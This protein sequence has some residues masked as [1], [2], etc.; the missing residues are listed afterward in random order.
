MAKKGDPIIALDAAAAR[1]FFL[2]ERQYNTL[3]LPHYFSFQPVLDAVSKR[4]LSVPLK[5]QRATNPREMEGVNYRILTNKNGLY[6]WRPFELIHPALYVSLVHT[7][8]E[9]THWAEIKKRFAEFQTNRSIKCHSIPVVPN[10]GYSHQKAQIYNWWEEIEQRSIELAL[11]Y[12][13]IIH[14]DVTDCYGSIYTHSIHWALSTKPVAKV[15]KKSKGQ[16]RVGALIDDHLQDMNYGQT[17][18]IPQGSVLMDF[19]A[20]IVLGHVD[21]LLTDRLKKVKKGDY[22]IL[23]YRDDYRIFTKGSSLGE[24]ILKELSEVLT[25]MGLKLNASKT[26]ASQNII[27]SSVKADKLYWI[28]HGKRA[29]N[30]QKWLLQLHSLSEDYPDSGTLDTQMRKFLDVMERSDKVDS[31]PKTLASIVTD[32]ACRNPRVGATAIGILTFLIKQVKGKRS[33]A[34]L[35]GRVS[36][37][38]EQMPNSDYWMVWLQRLQ[39]GI[40]DDGRLDNALT[41]KVHDSTEVIWN[42]EW[43]DEPLRRLIQSNDIIDRDT[44]SKVGE[45]MTEAEI[46]LL[47]MDDYLPF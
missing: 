16:R 30:K 7:I 39:L 25:D 4:L 18:G 12:D 21:E 44:L 15:E 14:T 40:G 6:A 27:R 47:S 29:G 32:I 28:A 34:A 13:H 2:D 38:F 11:D 41:R 22:Q 31:Y 36:Q 20:E 42:S 45:V 23:R 46:S 9:E 43:L 24:L 26:W 33:K 3:K 37:R 1:Q 5:D 17:N 19:I 8:T 10:E 35:V